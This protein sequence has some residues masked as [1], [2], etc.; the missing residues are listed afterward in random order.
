VPCLSLGVAADG[1]SIDGSGPQQTPA[2]NAKEGGLSH[3]LTSVRDLLI[4]DDLSLMMRTSTT[5]AMRGESMK[6]GWG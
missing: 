5:H 4:S 1:A 3:V 6:K 2:R